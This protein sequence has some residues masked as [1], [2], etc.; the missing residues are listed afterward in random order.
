[1]AALKK[2]RMRRRDVEEKL[3]MLASLGIRPSAPFDFAQFLTAVDDEYYDD[4]E[5]AI[6][7]Q[8]LGG[9]NVNPE[10]PEHPQ[11]R[12][13]VLH[14]CEGWIYDE[15]TLREFVD[16]LIRITNN[17]IEVDS[18]S[19]QLILDIPIPHISHAPLDWALRSEVYDQAMEEGLMYVHYSIIANGK[20]VTLIHQQ[21]GRWVDLRILT[22][23]GA[24]A[25]VRGKHNRFFQV[26]DDPSILTFGYLPLATISRLQELGVTLERCNSCF[27]LP[28]YCVEDV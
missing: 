13:A 1:M 15:N 4:D 23:I 20:K 16:G 10:D 2:A 11:P 7:L 9:Y 26:V 12:C 24:L 5:L 6:L 21:D 3:V 14:S 28:Y 19:I 27:P 22:V 25:R 17:D 8:F 18:L